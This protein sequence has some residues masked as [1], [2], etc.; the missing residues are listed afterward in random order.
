MILGR[1]GAGKSTLARE[2]GERTGLPVIE[3]DT[4]FCRRGLTSADPIQ[5]TAWQRELAQRDAWIIYG[6]LG[7]Y[8]Q[9]LAIRLRAADSIIVLDFALLRSALR[10]LPRGRERADY[11]CW[12]WA[13]RRRYLPQIM[14]ATAENAPHAR[15][16]VLRSPSMVRRFIA[17]QPG[18]FGR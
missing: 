6:D 8:D 14:E 15:V 13:Y 12:V 18:G 7:P 5:W 17:G 10:T 16:H 1:G 3:L 9:A 4:L 11:W 2:L